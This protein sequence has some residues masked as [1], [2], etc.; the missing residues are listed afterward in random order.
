M[1]ERE[2]EDKRQR[3]RRSR[4]VS[5][6]ACVCVCPP[7]PPCLASGCVFVCVCVYVNTR[8]RTHMHTH[9]HTNTPKNN[10]INGDNMIKVKKQCPPK[11]K[12]DLDVR[13]ERGDERART[14]CGPCHILCR[15]LHV[16]F[17]FI[18]FH[19]LFAR[20]SFFCTRMCVCT[21]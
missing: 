5:V 10:T 12:I 2:T 1:C 6:C 18:F 4:G 20:T 14:F 13:E 11:M 7:R 16:F 15:C 8:A 9:T 3:E 17:I 19:V 21:H